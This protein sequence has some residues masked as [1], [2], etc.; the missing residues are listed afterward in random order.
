MYVLHLYAQFLKDLD[1]NQKKLFQPWDNSQPHLDFAG[2]IKLS[3]CEAAQHLPQDCR[4]HLGSRCAEGALS[5]DIWLTEHQQIGRASGAVSGALGRT[6]TDMD[7][8][9]VMSRG[10]RVH[11]PACASSLGLQW[12]SSS[13]S[14]TDSA[15]IWVT[16][17][18]AWCSMKQMWGGTAAVSIRT[19]VDLE[20]RNLPSVEKPWL[21]GGWFLLP[22][23]AVQRALCS[24]FSLSSSR[25]VERQKVWVLSIAWAIKA[26]KLM[27]A[28]VHT[29][30]GIWGDNTVPAHLPH[31]LPVF[32]SVLPCLCGLF[33]YLMVEQSSVSSH[34]QG[35]FLYS[36]ISASLPASLA[37]RKPH[38]SKECI[39]FSHLLSIHNFI[40]SPITINRSTQRVRTVCHFNWNVCSHFLYISLGVFS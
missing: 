36:F 16:L 1:P 35:L 7:M 31:S 23:L 24:V 13:I 12:G 2:C 3:S 11:W 17:Q 25:I 28:G 9:T 22:V 26:G 39:H 33:C 38:G 4:S 29:S 18:K 15:T 27:S 5:R 10:A 19:P 21:L 32:L 37:F 40:Y 8:V 34:H 6:L 14:D 30:G 20:A